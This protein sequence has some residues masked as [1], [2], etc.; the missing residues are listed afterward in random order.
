M[1]NAVG[2]SISLYNWDAVEKKAKVL[3]IDRSKY[4]QGLVDKD[5][6]HKRIR[7]YTMDIFQISLILILFV[8]VVVK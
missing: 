2:K 6:N 5:L 4:I 7:D 3:K 1:S 8:I